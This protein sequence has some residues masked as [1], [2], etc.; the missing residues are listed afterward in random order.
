MIK[1]QIS[2]FV[3]LLLLL[4][5]LAASTTVN[6]AASDEGFDQLKFSAAGVEIKVFIYRPPDCANPSLLFVFHGLNRKAES[7]RKKAVKIA[8]NACLMVFA[9]LFDKDRFPN[10]R[11]HRAGVV[12]K[13]EVQP[14]SRWTA[15]IFHD[16]LDLARKLTRKETGSRNVKLYLFGHSAGAQFLSRIAAYSPPLN[17]DRIIIANPSVY[18]APLLSVSAP[19]GF[20]GVFPSVQAQHKL[21]AY[22]SL[23]ITIYLGQQDTGDKNLVKNKSAMQQGLNRLDRG[24]KIFR[25]ARDIARQHGWPFKWQLVEVAGVGHSSRGMLGAPEFYRALELHS[26]PNRIRLPDAAHSNHDNSTTMSAT[27]SRYSD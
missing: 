10:W 19:Y 5:A 8:Q 16:L 7:V 6:A 18:V 13:G 12:R 4:L 23:P 11:Y 27:A 21:K 25:L 15:P 3:F 9:P 1:A 14:V 22:L 20:A 24:R 2:G 26:A 17:V